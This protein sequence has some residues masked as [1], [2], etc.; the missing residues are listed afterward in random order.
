MIIRGRADQFRYAARRRTNITAMSD[1]VYQPAL[2]RAF[3]RL[4]QLSLGLSGAI[5]R[6]SPSLLFALRLWVS[7][8]LALYVAFWLELDKPF[9]AGASAAI[10]CQP[11]LG[12]SLRKG[13]FRL[14]GILVGAVFIVVLTGFF[15]QDHL[16]YLGLLAMWGGL[17]AF[18]ATVLRNFASYAAA[19]AGYT[20]V[21]IAADTLGATGG[22]SPDVFWVAVYRASEISIGIVCAGIVLAGSDLGGAQ[23]RLEV[24][25]AGF[26]A[27]ITAQFS[28]MLVLVGQHLPDT[29]AQRREI[30]FAVSSRSIRQS[31]RPSENRASC[32]TFAGSSDSTVRSVQRALRLARSCSAADNSPGPQGSS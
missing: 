15:P 22:A 21:I 13:W 27:E 20:A 10:V 17:C 31:I 3:G 26:A 14:I 7:V 5:G 29:R 8:C 9:W 18:G 25:F 4:A 1:I 19:L 23:Q 6:L 32:A 16:A 30:A 12:A 11:Q 2:H 28:R 24:S